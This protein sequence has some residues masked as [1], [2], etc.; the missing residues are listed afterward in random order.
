MIDWFKNKF[1]KTKE[2]SLKKDETLF[3]Q[4]Q[5]IKQDI[6]NIEK[7]YDTI[8]KRSLEKDFENFKSQTHTSYSKKAEYW[9]ISESGY[10]EMT[11]TKIKE[12]K[13]LELKIEYHLMD[14]KLK[15]NRVSLRPMYI[16]L[17]NK[18]LNDVISDYIM[19]VKIKEIKDQYKRVNEQSDLIDDVLDS[20]KIKRSIKL[21]KIFNDL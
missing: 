18:Y 11:L 16:T 6:D 2:T 15:I 7:N 5:L 10:T 21:N 1:R 3:D 14:D 20:K 19:F 9:A 4:Y 13:Y 17:D 8:V 12:D